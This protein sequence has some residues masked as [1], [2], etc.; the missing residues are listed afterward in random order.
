MPSF[1]LYEYVGYIVPGSVLLV[2]LM[3]LCPWIKSEFSG[4]TLANVGVFLIVTFLLGHF[5]HVVAHGIEKEL[6]LA[7]EGGVYGEDAAVNHPGTLLTAAELED[8][9]TK[10]E[11]KFKVKL[12]A[13]ITDYVEWCNITL[14]IEDAVNSAKHGA[15]LSTFIKDYGL[16][17]GLTTAFGLVFVIYFP[18]AFAGTRPISVP[19]PRMQVRIVFLISLIG[20]CLALYRML[21]FARLFTRE[22]FVSFLAVN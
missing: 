11:Q 8:L 19:P 20:F 3:P 13:P 9:S 6:Q 2:C 18:L 14:R 15:L 1:D 5:L 7:C 10:V 22:Q 16:Y 4:G 12:K 17:L 21:Y